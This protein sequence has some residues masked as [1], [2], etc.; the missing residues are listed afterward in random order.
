[1]DAY[2]QHIDSPESLISY[3]EEMIDEKDEKSKKFLD[4]AKIIINNRPGT[5]EYELLISILLKKIPQKILN[6]ALRYNDGQYKILNGFRK[7][8]FTVLREKIW[9]HFFV[10][11]ESI[12]KY[13]N[14][15]YFYVDNPQNS[16]GLLIPAYKTN[17]A[18]YLK[19]DSEFA[20][21]AN[22]LLVISDLTSAL[23]KFSNNKIEI[24]SDPTFPILKK[25]LPQDVELVINSTNSFIYNVSA[26]P[27]K[28][29]YTDYDAYTT[30]KRLDQINQPYP[31]GFALEDDTFYKFNKNTNVIHVINQF[32]SG[33]ELRNGTSK[34]YE[35]LGISV[36]QTN[37]LMFIV[38]KE[39]LSADPNIN[40][41]IIKQIGSCQEKY[42]ITGLSIYKQNEPGHQ[43]IFM[44]N[45]LNG[46]GYIYDP[47]YEANHEVSIGTSNTIRKYLLQSLKDY[48]PDINILT[49]EKSSCNFDFSLQSTENDRYCIA[50]SY[51]IVI[52]YIMN[53]NM[54]FDQVV[55]F[56]Y[57]L[58]RKNFKTVISRFILF[59]SNPTLVDVAL[60]QDE[61]F[62]NIQ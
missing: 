53:E 8:P 46:R 15:P 18:T 36:C 33:L 51:Y 10:V 6:S 55:D 26:S 17:N 60:E 29:D 44:L 28:I 40:P 12:S 37:S 25:Y 24:T 9:H 31:K 42:S 4:N 3:L 41:K 14:I 35:K 43:M 59:I 21:R 11:K 30:M 19:T 27:I 16:P 61:D 47:S 13:T 50:W 48:F 49:N 45:V 56:I 22:K 54:T 58:G 7:E 52:L 5:K 32:S 38:G 20:F 1:M 57:S 39:N 34:I 23:D 2:L 62:C